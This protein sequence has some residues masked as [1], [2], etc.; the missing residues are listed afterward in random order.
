VSWHRKRPCDRPILNLGLSYQTPTNIMHEPKDLGL[1]SP[2]LPYKKIPDGMMRIL[3][4]Y[5]N[6]NM[7]NITERYL[8]RKVIIP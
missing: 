5:Y 7:G 8:K 6:Q 1:N 3:V 4:I 2:I